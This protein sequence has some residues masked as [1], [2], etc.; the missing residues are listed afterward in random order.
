MEGGGGD[1]DGLKEAGFGFEPDVKL[2]EMVAGVE[3][4]TAAQ[5]E[6]FADLL[7]GG[8]VAVAGA[9]V[10]FERDFVDVGGTRDNEFDRFKSLLFCG[11]GNAK[12]DQLSFGA[13]G[14][15]RSYDL[16]FEL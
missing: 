16:R 3:L 12:G 5:G 14:K 13:V 11:G 7:R 1:D 10:V 9:S 4:E 15:K 6:F 2:V 8:K